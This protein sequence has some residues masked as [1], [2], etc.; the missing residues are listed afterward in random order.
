MW[1][2]AEKLKLTPD[3]PTVRKVSVRVYRDWDSFVLQMALNLNH[4]A[5][6][7]QNVLGT[8]KSPD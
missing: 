5:Q 1:E 2:V 7:W 3:A 8:V 4:V 6:Q